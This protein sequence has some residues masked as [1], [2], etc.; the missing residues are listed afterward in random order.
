MDK[1]G[2][3]GSRSRFEIDAE[4]IN[5]LSVD[6]AAL[7]RSIHNAFVLTRIIHE[8]STAAADSGMSTELRSVGPRRTV[9]YACG[10]RP[11]RRP[12]RQM[13]LISMPVC[14]VSLRIFMN[15]PG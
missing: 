13:R 7:F 15:N 10:I 2:D 12:K 1:L 5:N 11:S 9:E 3:E 6:Y 4:F 14:A 8:V